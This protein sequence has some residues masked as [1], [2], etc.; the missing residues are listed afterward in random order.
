KSFFNMAWI[1]FG[2]AFV[3][4][5]LG[6]IYMEAD[7]ATKGFLAMSYLFS[8]TS[9][10]TLAKVVRDRHEAERFINKVES[11]KTEKFLNESHSIGN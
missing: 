11:A 9:C 3:G 2:I 1:A 5:C 4:M 10:F 7:L 8:V 6:L